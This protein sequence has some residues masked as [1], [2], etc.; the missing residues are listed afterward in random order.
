MPGR[1]PIY[2]ERIRKIRG[3]FSWIEHH[4]VHGGFLR[5]L[6]RDELLLW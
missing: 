1:R 3:S 5:A 2:P 4:F 6:S